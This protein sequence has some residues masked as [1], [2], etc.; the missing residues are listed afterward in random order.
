MSRVQ[1]YLDFKW[2]FMGVR[3]S[4]EN[5]LKV[6]TNNIGNHFNGILDELRFYEYALSSQEV[7]SVALNG[8]MK[9]QTSTVSVPPV[10][11]LISLSPRQNGSLTVTGK[12]ISKDSENP[13]VTIYYGKENGGFEFANWEYSVQVNAGQPIPIG[14]FNA[15]VNGLIPGEKYF[16]RAY[17][18]SADGEDW[19]V[20]H[21]K[22]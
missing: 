5:D 7:N 4:E 8:T 6:G 16:F 2:G 13:S 15:T 12:L 3:T 14:E 17:A 20:E 21:Q 9:F 22:L 19:S 1:N 11:E 10:I 18:Q